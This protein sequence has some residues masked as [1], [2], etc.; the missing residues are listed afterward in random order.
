M[1]SDVF[2]SANH[3]PCRQLKHLEKSMFRA[4]TVDISDLKQKEASVFHEDTVSEPYLSFDSNMDKLR[5]LPQK[6]SEKNFANF[7]GTA[8]KLV[9]PTNTIE[10]ADVALLNLQQIFHDG[11]AHK[12]APFHGYCLYGDVLAQ[13]TS[14]TY[15]VIRE[16]ELKAFQACQLLLQYI[17][18]SIQHLGDHEKHY[19]RQARI[20]IE[21]RSE[22]HKKHHHLKSQ[23]KVLGRE[24][25][26]MKNL[27]RFYENLAGK[28]PKRADI[29]PKDLERMEGTVKRPNEVDEGC[30]VGNHDPSEVKI[31][32]NRSCNIKLDEKGSKLMAKEETRDRF[33]QVDRLRDD[34][35]S[36]HE[37][38]FR[39]KSFPPTSH[40]KEE[41][42]A[43]SLYKIARY[44]VPWITKLREKR[45]RTQFAAANIIRQHI[46]KL[47]HFQK[48]LRRTQAEQKKMAFEDSVSG[49]LSIIVNTAGGTGRCHEDRVK[50]NSGS[51]TPKHAITDAESLLVLFHKVRSILIELNING[52]S[53]ERVFKKWDTSNDDEL[54]RAEFRAGI[55]QISGYKVK[56]RLVRALIGLIRQN[57]GRSSPI[58]LRISVEEF[59]LGLHLRQDTKN[60]E[61]VI[62]CD[63]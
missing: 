52:V 54:D 12:L 48:E 60:S 27:A 59:Q 19:A 17:S 9:A 33:V 51:E 49:Q 58:P 6:K 29:A 13:D 22:L 53:Y 15:F 56:R 31:A 30:L 35:S 39:R 63:S 23:K 16:E 55:Y 1:R 7:T 50:H 14:Q 10:W 32:Q 57:A 46:K 8:F 42:L 45:R 41:R 37:M 24:L 44:M 34:A 21:K 20:L 11:E 25:G 38:L 28:T 43:K 62:E 5:A 61:Q 2:R 18:H 47:L 3:A 26:E 36:N 40:T 4:N